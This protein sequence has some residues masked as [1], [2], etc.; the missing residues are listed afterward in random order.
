M[1]CFGEPRP[2]VVAPTCAVGDWR[3]EVC[4]RVRCDLPLTFAAKP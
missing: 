4:W 2:V 1:D 3:A